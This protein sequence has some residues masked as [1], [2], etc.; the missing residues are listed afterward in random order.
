VK[1]LHNTTG[2]V[3]EFYE[4][5]I[6]IVPF[7]NLTRK[8]FP[9]LTSLFMHPVS[10]SEEGNKSDAFAIRQYTKLTA[11]GSDKLLALSFYPLNLSSYKKILISPP[12]LR[13][14]VFQQDVFEGDHILVYLL[15]SGYM[16]D[17]INWHKDHPEI[18]L[19]C[20]TDSAT[21]KGK[22]HFDETL[23]FHSL[24]DQK[25]LQYMASAKALVT[26]AGLKVLKPCI[27]AN[28]CDGSVKGILN[29]GAMQRWRQ[30]VPHMPIL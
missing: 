25:F 10:I 30:Q 16:Q 2:P 8:L 14:E 24:D 21:V 27:S 5:L 22:W 6:G 1:R 7:K 13:K 15:N 4:P 12:L 11:R 29:N 17:I 18:E 19:H 9:S 26:T 3:A 28:Q 23:C 20:F